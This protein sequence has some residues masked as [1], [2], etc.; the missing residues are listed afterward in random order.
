MGWRLARTGDAIQ[1]GFI[2][3]FDPRFWTVNFP[4]PMMA[5][6]TTPAPDMLRIDATFL[7]RNDLAGIIW[8]AEDADDHPLLAY[9][10]ARDFR[11]C[12]L[13]F[14][15]RSAGVRALDMVDGPVL[16]IEGRDAAGVPRAWYVRLWNYAEGDPE[17]AEISLNFAQLDGG[18]A[19]PG[20]ADRVW[21]GD[22]DRMFISLVAPAHDG[23]DAPLTMPVD[24]WVELSAVACD[25]PGSV[26]GIGDTIVPAHGFRIATGYDDLYHLTPARVLRNIVQLGYRGVINHYV[27]MSHYPR[28]VWNGG[29]GRYLAGEAGLCD[30]CVAWHRD[31]ARRALDLG[32][33]VIWSLSYE[34][35]D[36]HCA[37]GWKQ[38]AENGEPA[39]TGWD[40]PSTLLSPANGVAMAWLREIARAFV[41]IATETGMAVRFQIGEPWWWVVPGDGRICLYD[42]AARE[43]L[44]GPV[45][46]PDVRGERD[47][48]QRALLDRAGELLAESTL[49]LRD[50][51]K[52]DA[53][54][55][56]VAILVYLPTVLD[57]AAPE[58]KRANVPV[59]WAH[60][61]FDR[62]QLEDYDWVTA[63]DSGSTG[64]G[65]AEMGVRLGYPIGEQHYFSGFVL[66][67][68]D[69]HQWWA[70]HDA[71][72][73]SQRRG[74]ADTFVWALPQI[75]RD[76]FTMFA[77]GDGEDAVQ[78]FDDVD[79]P[80]AIGRRALV[81]P[82]FSTA[83]VTTAAGI[84]Q[85]N[86]DWADARMRFDA[87]PGVRSQADIEA[88]IGFFRA[89]HGP[90]RG[91]RFR[92]PLDHSSWE[93]TGSPGFA[94]QMLGT[95]DGV[96]TRFALRKYYGE[97][98]RRITRPVPGTVRVS[99]D[100]LEQLGGWTLEAGGVIAFDDAVAVGQL[101]RAGFLFDVPVRFA[102]DRLEVALATS[103]AGEAATVPLIEI[104]E[105][106]A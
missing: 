6:A 88:L 101:V 105:G 92:D 26:L 67:G 106:G 28:L 18:F 57:R 17:D 93:M 19:L 14:R 56:E 86:A 34:L 55:A 70:I 54:D 48:A 30:P 15:W 5:A 52:A 1:T 4:R 58:L 75:L 63:G 37:E 43:A 94:D 80:I 97:Q 9:E 8:A 89:R 95:G 21:A 64:R 25:G 99:I 98:E 42:A 39:L 10:T 77:I 91:F 31:F 79:F 60:P 35:L 45:S 29:A 2:K 7:R 61:A 51:V 3:R 49:S 87:G 71:A 38:R 104:R 13:R 84:E 40:P 65:I 59:G 27:G 41:A 46:I 78:A 11:Q 16:T 68:E 102:E 90:A 44:G 100:G 47:P 23:T 66:R 74:A 24:G 36:Q 62:L 82:S 69:R 72:L 103:A 22:V 12:V 76:G 53:T 33:E 32:Q 85:R 96:R 20:E 73:A 81:E 50:A 83:I